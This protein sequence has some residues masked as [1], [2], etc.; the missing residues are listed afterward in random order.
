MHLARRWRSAK[1]TEFIGAVPGQLGKFLTQRRVGLSAIKPA[2]QFIS[3]QPSVP[4]GLQC[5]KTC[6][7]LAIDGDGDIFASLNAPQRSCGVIAQLSR[8]HFRH[9]TYSLGSNRL[10]GWRYQRRPARVR[11]RIPPRAV[12]A[13]E[14][15][16]PHA[17]RS[18]HVGRGI[19][20]LARLAGEWLWPNPQRSA[21]IGR[22][23]PPLALLALQ[24][25]R[26]VRW[27]A[28]VRLR[29]PPLAVGAFR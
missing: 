16:R 22:R 3:T 13:C 23:V 5:S 24:S 18:A 20:P 10:S 17:E 12:V 27:A 11:D 8:G 1:R 15:L 2:Q 25:C 19:P 6:D 14:R 7:R 9:S 21:L 29:I 28:N 4:G 26:C